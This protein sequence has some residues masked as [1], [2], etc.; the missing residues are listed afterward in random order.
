MYSHLI[1]P[2]RPPHDQL[3]LAEE[4]QSSPKVSSWKS[5]LNL[6]QVWKTV[7]QFQFFFFFFFFKLF[8]NYLDATFEN[9]T[10]KYKTERMEG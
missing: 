2:Q 9:L 1:K 4:E 8:F 5:I 3:R 6:K 7:T 10:L